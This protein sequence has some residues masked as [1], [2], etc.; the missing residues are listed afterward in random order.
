MKINKIIAGLFVA[1][2]FVS[3]FDDESSVAD[4]SSLSEITIVEGSINK[5]YNIQ[6]NETLTISPSF[7]QSNVEKPLKYTWE[8]DLEPYSYEK[9]FLYVGNKLGS[10][11]CR[12]IVENEDGKTFFPFKLNVNSP[13]EEGITVLS[14]DTEGRPM[15]SFMQT[16]ADKN[17]VGTFTTAELLT[18]NNDD[19]YFS[20]NPSDM[21]HSDA[22]LFIACKGSDTQGDLPAVYYLN[23]KTFIVENMFTVPEYPAFKPQKLLIPTSYTNYVLPLYILSDDGSIYNFT[24]TQAALEPSPKFAYKYAMATHMDDSNGAYYSLVMWDNEAHALVNAYN[25][26]YG[27]YYL[28]PIRHTDRATAME[29]A[30]NNYFAGLDFVTMVTVRATD[31]QKRLDGNEIIVL[32]KKGIMAYRT[33]VESSFWDRDDVG[34]YYMLVD[35]NKPSMVNLG[36]TLSIDEHT[37][38]IA[39]KTYLT[40]FFAEGNKVRKWNYTTSQ[41]LSA[42]STH[43]TVGS[44]DAVITGFEMS[45]DQKTTYVAFYEPTQEGKNGS[46]WAFDTDKGTVLNKWENISYKPVKMIYKY[47]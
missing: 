12:L 45:A 25:G 13:Y 33:I 39:S 31:A 1:T 21:L 42:A 22:T 26:G 44:D 30:E 34:K 35:K 3:C 7:T 29:K 20:S 18:L 37:P 16:P 10:Y 8:V 41:M 19:I 28:G 9:D 17:E 27:P 11:N 32:T 2:M 47:K 36:G 5:E 43:L 4:L 15:L 46:V 14:A 24:V 23:E 38:C 6:R 40:M